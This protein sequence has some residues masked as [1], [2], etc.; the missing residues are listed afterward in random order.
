VRDLEAEAV[1][2]ADIASFVAGLHDP[3]AVDGSEA[4]PDQ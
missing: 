1:E 3:E 2:D 4:A